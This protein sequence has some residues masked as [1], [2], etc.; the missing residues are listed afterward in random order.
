[1]AA[2]SQNTQSRLGVILSVCMVLALI[3]CGWLNPTFYLLHDPPS[4]A[5]FDLVLQAASDVPDWEIA[6]IDRTNKKI[7]MVIPGGTYTYTEDKYMPY[8]KWEKEWRKI[9]GKK[10]KS[11]R[12]KEV[13]RTGPHQFILIRMFP[14]P[15][16]STLKVQSTTD[17]GL[18][19]FEK[20]IKKLLGVP[21]DKRPKHPPE[22]EQSP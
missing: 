2:N 7:L 4:D 1:M 8:T 12:Y 5:T 9:L 22:T 18:L 13:E 11:G 10:D 14:R 17:K 21:I 3:G 15:Q 20:N 16:G 19:T 6:S